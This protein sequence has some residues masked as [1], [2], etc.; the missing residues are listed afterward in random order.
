MLKHFDITAVVRLHKVHIVIEKPLAKYGSNLKIGYLDA[1][2]ILEVTTAAIAALAA[3]TVPGAFDVPSVH[4][5]II[6]RVSDITTAGVYVT[7]RIT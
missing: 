6:I 4:V 7:T 3:I 2:N 5:P 1:D